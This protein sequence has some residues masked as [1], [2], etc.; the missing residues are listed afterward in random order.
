MK[1]IIG[2]SSDIKTNIVQK[3]LRELNLR[4][5][6]K[7]IRVSS[8]VID[9]PLDKETTQQ[10]ARNRAT[11]ARKAKPDADFWIG[12]EG[13]LH[14][15]G[16]GYHLVTFSCLVDQSGDEF[17]G[18]GVE[19]HLPENVSDEV[20]NGNQFGEAIRIYA[21]EAFQNAYANYLKAK[22]GLVYR[23]KVNTVIL[24]SNNQILLL[25]LINY[26]DTDW[27]TPGG[28]IEE[29]ETPEEAVFRELK[30]ELGTDKFE[31]IE[32]SKII[33][34]YEFPDFVV[35]QQIKK[36]N[37]YKGQKQIQFIVRF[38]GTNTEIKTQDEEIRA[39]IWVDYRDL[40]TYLNFPGQWENVR[41]VIEKSSVKAIIAGKI[42]RNYL[43]HQEK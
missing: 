20:K 25:Q 16:E 41:E 7:K 33:N 14:D 19:V 29:G 1:V 12:L 32:K 6:V 21:K 5:E 30:E 39:H 42:A 31:I 9:Q 34:K 8:Q 18:E 4:A 10:G 27:N 15:Y 23:E 17:I 37:Q 13:G 24:N 35:V 26:G 11:N 3:A 2:S 36:G 43:H 28:G 40:E 38:S 22:G